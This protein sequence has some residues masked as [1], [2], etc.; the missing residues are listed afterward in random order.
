MKACRLRVE[1]DQHAI[2]GDVRLLSCG[3][4]VYGFPCACDVRDGSL[5]GAR[6]GTR[7]LETWC[8]RSGGEGPPGKHQPHEGYLSILAPS[9]LAPWTPGMSLGS[10]PEKPPPS[11]VGVSRKHRE[12]GAR[13]ALSTLVDVMS[14]PVPITGGGR[15]SG[16]SPAGRPRGRLGRPATW[17]HPRPSR[18][19]AWSDSIKGIC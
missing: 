2:R 16:R 5:P 12:P 7:S 4:Q 19:T 6:K 15:G 17:V 8:C 11:G 10:D 1:T 3:C 9:Q 18:A 13:P 14:T